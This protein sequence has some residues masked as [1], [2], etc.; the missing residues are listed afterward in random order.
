MNEYLLEAE[1]PRATKRG[2]VG[3]KLKRPWKRERKE[4]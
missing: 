2:T 4:A 3:R 1:R